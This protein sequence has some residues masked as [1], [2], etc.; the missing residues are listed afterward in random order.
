MQDV[1]TH[2]RWIAGAAAAWSMWGP[3][4]YLGAA[5]FAIN[6]WFYDRGVTNPAHADGV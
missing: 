5:L 3:W 4:F 6:L 1:P 2:H